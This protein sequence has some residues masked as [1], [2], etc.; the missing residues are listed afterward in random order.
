M[1]LP[2]KQFARLNP[3]CVSSTLSSTVK[4]TKQ[5]GDVAVAM[6]LAALLRSGK[7]VLTPFGDRHSY[8]LVTEE[9]G[10]FT[11][12]QCKSALRK[13]DSIRFNLCSVVRDTASKRWVKKPYGA[14]VDAFGV[15]SPDTGKCY[16]V[17]TD[18]VGNISA[19]L[20]LRSVVRRDQLTASEFEIHGP[21]GRSPAET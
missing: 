3:G 1:G 19:S 11:R 15:Y 10:L 21:A 14:S 16:L 9:G 12:I 6:V 4:D 20:S 18:R 2:A 7:N 13:G 8:D 17:P 5:I